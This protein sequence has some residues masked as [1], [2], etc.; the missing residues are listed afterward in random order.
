MKKFKEFTE[1]KGF[2]VHQGIGSGGD[3]VM[4]QLLKSLKKSGGAPDLQKSLERRLKKSGELEK[5]H[6]KKGVAFEETDVEEMSAL[7]K[8]K[9]KIARAARGPSKK[10]TP[11]AFRQTG[12][13]A[14][15]SRERAQSAKIYH[16]GR[17]TRDKNK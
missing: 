17:M 9:A 10:A 15:K 6:T 3:E 14:R 4:K 8:I 12:A 13:A 7:T 1:A 5:K 16:S 11:T 2:T